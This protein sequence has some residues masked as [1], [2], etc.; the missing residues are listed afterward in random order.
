[1]INI[2][3]RL[4]TD[5]ELVRNVWDRYDAQE[6]APKVISS[7]IASLKRLLSE[8]PALLGQNSQM[9]GL[10]VQVEATSSAAAAVD[11][12]GQR[13]AYRNKDSMCQ[14]I[15]PDKATNA[16][17]VVCPPCLDQILR[18]AFESQRINVFSVRRARVGEHK[19]ELNTSSSCGDGSC[20]PRQSFEI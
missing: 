19:N 14:N 15:H 20:G 12:A 9:W 4:C 18:F 16:W 2:L 17:S 8:K 6:Q 10:G 3:N 7:L 5:S 13:P 11:M 1:M